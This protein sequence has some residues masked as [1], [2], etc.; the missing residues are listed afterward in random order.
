MCPSRGSKHKTAPLLAEGLGEVVP[1]I[2]TKV[3]QCR[4]LNINNGHKPAPVAPCR[5][6]VTRPVTDQCKAA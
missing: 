6:E 2:R 3:Y 1:D 4:C 5:L